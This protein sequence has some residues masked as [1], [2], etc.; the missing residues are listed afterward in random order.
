MLGDDVK[1]FYPNAEYSQENNGKWT[2][3][4]Y[5][6]RLKILNN[7]LSDVSDLYVEARLEKISVEA[8]YKIQSNAINEA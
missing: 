1:E 6:N 7:K 5:Y 2:P 3:Q 4:N 8:E